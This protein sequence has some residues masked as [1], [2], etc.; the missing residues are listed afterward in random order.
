MNEQEKEQF[1]GIIE[2]IKELRLKKSADYGNSWKIF[3]LMGV[4]YQ[5]M[6][7]SIRI[8]NLTRAGKDPK[9]ESL[10][11]SFIDMANYAIMAA[12]LIDMNE[13]EPKI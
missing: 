3:G 12:Q 2:S 1:I 8:W 10:R 5:I 11:D 7:K 13:T 9:N 4:V 6:S